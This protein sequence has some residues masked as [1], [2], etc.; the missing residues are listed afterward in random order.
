MDEPLTLW[1]TGR[2]LSAAARR[3]EKA[4]NDHLEAWH[5]N[6]ASLP[7]LAL[8]ARSDHSQRELAAAVAVTEQ[9]MSRILAR[10]ER[11]GYVARVRSADDRRRHVVTLLPAGSAVLTTASDPELVE[12]IS[13]TG[14]D[15]A[16]VAALR[17]AL[18]ALLSARGEDDAV[19][20]RPGGAGQ[21]ED[22][23]AT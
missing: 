7:V 5:L 21:T 12:S 23:A 20:R 9:T 19:P 11:L 2:L 1:P 14:L 6:H 3:V 16:Q 17:E 22:P 4:W 8:L 10:L 15:A 18:V 13:T